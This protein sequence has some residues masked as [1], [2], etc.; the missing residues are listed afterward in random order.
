[1]R[2]LNIFLPTFATALAFSVFACSGTSEDAAGPSDNSAQGPEQDI[3]STTSQLEGSWTIDKN[4]EQLSSVV[5][6][7]FDASG[8]FSRDVNQILNGVFV[9]NGRPPPQHQTGTY[10]VDTVKHVLTLNVTAPRTFTEVVSYAYTPARVLNGMFLPGKEPS[11][12]ARLTL[13]GIAA[14]GSMI[15]YPAITY[16]KQEDQS[17]SS[18]SSSGSST[19]G[20]TSSGG[21][22]CP[23]FLPQNCQVCADGSS[24]CAHWVVENGTC[25]IE[26]CPK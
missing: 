20:G 1:M 19:S 18:S 3:T 12:A 11:T 25:T 10:T 5:S 24:Q 15:A 17:G 8:T 7:K 6:Y 13:T 21:V 14:P 16:D 4:S 9:G 2:A 22:T 23:G 26:T